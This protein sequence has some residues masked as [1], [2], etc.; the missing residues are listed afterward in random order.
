MSICLYL[1]LAVLV[2]GQQS[3]VVVTESMLPTK[4]KIFIIWLFT[5]MFVNFWQSLQSMNKLSYRS[6]FSDSITI[7]KCH[8][9]LSWVMYYVYFSFPVPFVY[10][11]NC[12]CPLCLFALK[13]LYLILTLTNSPPVVQICLNAFR[14]QF[15]LLEDNFFMSL[16][17]CTNINW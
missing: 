1:S 15:Y 10:T 12:K 4:P 5:K 8:S 14:Y 3:W 9:Q 2:P 17:A 7:T 13:Y 6:I 11:H 16:L